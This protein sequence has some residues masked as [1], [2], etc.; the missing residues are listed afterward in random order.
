MMNTHELLAI[1]VGSLK[2]SLGSFR[3]S[4]LTLSRGSQTLQFQG[5]PLTLT[6]YIWNQ[7]YFCTL[8]I[9][10]KPNGLDY[11]VHFV[12]VPCQS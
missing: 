6:V 2:D 9:T 5:L 10:T 4:N 11:W 1:Y 3:G 12:F 7:M 8:S